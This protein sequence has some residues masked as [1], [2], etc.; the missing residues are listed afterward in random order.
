M[1]DKSFRYLWIG[2]SLANSGDVFYIV[3]LMSV[4]YKMTG[5]AFYMA[6]IP[7]AITTARFVSGL[8]A[9]ILMDRYSL[10]TLLVSSQAGKTFGLLIL[11][12]YHFFSVT[13]HIG[14]IFLLVFV[15]SYLDGWAIPASNAMIPRLV[16]KEELVKAN[17]FLSIMNESI[18]LGGWALGGILVAIMRGEN[19]IW[20]TFCLYLLSTLIQFFIKDQTQ[21]PNNK[22]AMKESSIVHSIKEGWAMIWRNPSLRLIHAIL[23]LESMANVV[24]IAAIIYVYVKEQLKMDESWWGY[25]NASFL[26]GLVV[27][28]FIALRFANLIERKLTRI[29]TVTSAGGCLAT[30]VFGFTEIPWVA[31]AV[32]AVFG[33]MEQLK[34]IGLQTILQ[35]RVADEKLP[36]IYAAQSS[37][38]SLLFGVS[39]LVFG[40]IT[41]KIDV[42]ATFLVS[43]ALLLIAAFCTIYFRSYLSEKGQI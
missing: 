6:V 24:W 16:P 1:K 13:D 22:L 10:K 7:F 42:R 37:L 17:S 26:L 34:S 11:G 33:M 30:L 8:F 32:S 14:P 2:Q 38:T 25:I 40:L 27:G 15:I 3:G 28:G 5:S 23:S 19:V 36:K 12:S 41:E 21:S 29:V 4:L 18:Q 43:T 9:P 39:S 31:L 35:K 20:L